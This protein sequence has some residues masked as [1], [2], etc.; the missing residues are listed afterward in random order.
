M[1]ILLT[2]AS[3]FT[4]YWFARQLS[5]AGHELVMPL[6]RA[7][8]EYEDVRRQR[9]D[10]I[11]AFGQTIDNC[12]FGDER[13]MRLIAD[14]DRWDVLCHHAADVTDYKSAD[15][16]VAGALRNN[17]HNLK[18]ALEA[19]AA[20][21]CQRLVLTGSVFEPGEGAGSEG[22][23]AFSPYG[24]SKALTAQV[25]D[26][27][28]Q[29]TD[30]HFGKF[31][32]A[33][34]FGPCEEPRFTR[35]LLRT[36]FA[37]ETASVRTPAYVRDNIHV[38]LLARAYARFV[39]DLPATAGQSKLNPSG[40]IE[41]QGAFAERFAREMRP[42][43]GLDCALELATQTE[44]T[45]PRIRINTDA[46]DAAALGWS[47]RDAWDAVAEDARRLFSVGVAGHE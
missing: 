23:P 26:Y 39:N 15:F 9:V 25:A 34:P 44:F 30:M 19:L 11:A 14:A 35:Y 4:G 8:H 3:S 13:F 42:R 29:Q 16:D 20:R 41:S 28:A 36:W 38:S 32:I 17:T 5:E 40:Y 27:Y 43:L 24:L 33:N 1:R 45:E 21:G 10:G 12:S 6:R 47:E 22:L 2:G 37:G 31:V 7:R 18:P 46:L